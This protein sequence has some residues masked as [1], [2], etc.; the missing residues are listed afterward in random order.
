STVELGRGVRRLQLD[1][2]GTA[3]EV[4]GLLAVFNRFGVD[5]AQAEKTLT[6]FSRGLRGDESSV[7]GQVVSL[8]AFSG[9][10]NEL[11]VE[12]TE[13]TEGLKLQIG[14]GVLPAFIAFAGGAAEVAKGVN[15]TALSIPKL[16]G[17]LG[18]LKDRFGE[19]AKLAGVL[20]LAIGAPLA[21][22]AIIG[23]K[24]AG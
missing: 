20:A 2:G 15:Q 6:M 14:L 16:F 11:G 8:K 4:S 3:E 17:P 5:G 10:M 13:A 24:L 7:D 1:I 23:A 21:I 22:P 12:S 9:V 18:E 19:T